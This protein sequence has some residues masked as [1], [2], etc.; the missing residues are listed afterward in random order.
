[1]QQT[2]K[3]SRKNNEEKKTKRV[4]AR[5]TNTSP[6]VAS[7]TIILSICYNSPTTRQA[8]TTYTAR[9]HRIALLCSA[10][11][12]SD[13]TASCVP[14]FD[15]SLLTILLLLSSPPAPTS[16]S[17]GKSAP[18]P[19]MSTQ[20]LPTSPMSCSKLPLSVLLSFSYCPCRLVVLLYSCVLVPSSSPASSFSPPLHLPCPSFSPRLYLRTAHLPPLTGSCQPRFPPKNMRPM[21]RMQALS[22]WPCLAVGLSGWL[23]PNSCTSSQELSV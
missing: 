5:S 11:F 20:T 16:W 22:T 21:R 10:A 7:C 12:I 19:S 4:V 1:M 9:L 2:D 8:I 15:C 18:C 17:S 6:S 23:L 14:F 13:S 3:T